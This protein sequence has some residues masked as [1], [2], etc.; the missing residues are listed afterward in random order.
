V[1]ASANAVECPRCKRT[2]TTALAREGDLQRHQC[3]ACGE[4]FTAPC[5]ET[6]PPD[7]AESGPASPRFAHLPIAPPDPSDGP[8][9]ERAPA[10]RCPKCQKP[11]FRLGKRY[12]DHVA[13][14]DGTPFISSR[15]RVSQAEPAA[16]APTPMPVGTAKALDLSIEALKAQRSALEAEISGINSAIATLEKIKGLGGAPSGPFADGA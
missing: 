16:P 7:A 10:D 9:T 1:I 14:C 13:S 6:K 15:P 11:Y 8:S 4:N 2:Q 5:V 12:D 3:L